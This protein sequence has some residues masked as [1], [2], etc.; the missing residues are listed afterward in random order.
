MRYCPLTR[1]PTHS[2]HPCVTL[3]MQLELFHKLCP[4]PG[5]APHPPF[6]GNAEKRQLFK[7]FGHL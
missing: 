5:E 4:P 6:P 1:A 3:D 7:R 2:L